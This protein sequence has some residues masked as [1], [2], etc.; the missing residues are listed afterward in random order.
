MSDECT[1]ENPCGKFQYWG[2]CGHIN[3]WVAEGSEVVS[4]PEPLTQ[5]QVDALP[6][7][8]E[9]EVVWIGGNGPHRYKTVRNRESVC[10]DNVYQDRL[11]YVG[12]K[13]LTE[14]RVASVDGGARPERPKPEVTK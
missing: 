14:V 9:V 6:D 11:A 7:G 2:V 13:P 3:T 10:V 1:R 8:T 12:R 4:A 5:S